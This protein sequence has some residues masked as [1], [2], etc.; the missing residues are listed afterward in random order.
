MECT[1]SAATY[2]YSARQIPGFY[3]IPTLITELKWD[4]HLLVTSITYIYIVY[5]GVF[6]FLNIPL[7]LLSQLFLGLSNG[8]FPSGFPNKRF[9]N[10]LYISVHYVVAV[11]ASNSTPVS[12]ILLIPNL[13]LHFIVHF[14]SPN[15]FADCNLHTSKGLF[16]FLVY[17]YE[18]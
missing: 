7:I 9:W 17:Y 2:N 6:Y 3:G 12:H 15:K 10:Y 14:C 4:C 16:V 1:P 13:C 18:I 5:T 8:I 11:E